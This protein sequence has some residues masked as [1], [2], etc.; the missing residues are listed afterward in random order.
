MVYLHYEHGKEKRDPF[1]TYALV[2]IHYAVLETVK[3]GVL[4]TVL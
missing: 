1:N 4:A 2:A 3:V